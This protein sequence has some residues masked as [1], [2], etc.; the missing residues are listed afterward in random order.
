LAAAHAHR[1]A[2]AARVTALDDEVAAIRANRQAGKGDA[3]DAGRITLIGM[4]REDL[5][6]MKTE[7]DQ[8]TVPY[9]RAADAARNAL[10]FA[11]QRL[12]GEK[13]DELLRRL[14]GHANQLATQLFA[15][16]GE[17][18][19]HKKR[20]NVPNAHLWSPSPELATAIRRIDLGVR[21]V[22]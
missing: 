8:A 16:I 21:G 13:Q 19:G 5:L 14:I 17:I 22:T 4:D 11:N 9:Q 7:A 12:E 1:D 2:I 20:L 18:E 15:T 3:N 10:A 6:V